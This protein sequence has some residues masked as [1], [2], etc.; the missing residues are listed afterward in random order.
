MRITHIV[1]Y[2]ILSSVD[3][4]GSR[5]ALLVPFAVHCFQTAHSCSLLKIRGFIWSGEGW[6]GLTA[7]FHCQKGDHKEDRATSSRGREIHRREYLTGE[8]PVGHRGKFF[9]EKVKYWDMGREW[10]L[11]P[12]RL[13]KFDWQ[14]LE[15][16]DT[17]PEQ[18]LA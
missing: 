13:L 12:W 17:T 15:Q 16:P 10:Y 8:I 9:L 5:S 14:G 7:F 4:R 3:S 2:C 6:G 1:K 18:P 11:H